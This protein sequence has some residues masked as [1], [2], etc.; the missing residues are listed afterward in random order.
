MEKFK[1]NRRDIQFFSKKNGKLLI[2]HSE[3]AFLARAHKRVRY[4]SLVHWHLF[5]IGRKNFLF[6][7]TPRGAKASAVMYSLIEIAKENGLNPFTY[8]DYIFKNAP[9]RSVRGNP[10]MWEQLMPWFMP[11]YSKEAKF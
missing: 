6:A 11:E 10:S 3:Q 1:S 5:I 7:N 4:G 8:L 2:L 9:D